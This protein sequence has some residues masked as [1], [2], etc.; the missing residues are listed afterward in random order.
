MSVGSDVLSGFLGAASFRAPERI[1]ESAWLQHAPFAYWLTEALA[2]RVV[3]ELGAHLGFSYFTFCEA[4]D[5]AGLDNKLYAVDT[6]AGDAQAGFYGE[7]V[8]A[9]VEAYN[10]KRFAG[11]STL[12]RMRFDDALGRFSDG[13]IDLLHI[14]GAHG[15]DDVRGDFEAWLPK[16]TPRGVVLLHDVAV[17]REGFGVARF[18]NEVRTR[19]P[20]FSFQHGFGL[21]VLGTGPDVPEAVG[22]L[23]ALDPGSPEAD[24]VRDAYARLGR[25]VQLEHDLRFGARVFQLRQTALETENARLRRAVPVEPGTDTKP[26]PGEAAVAALSQRLDSLSNQNGAALSAAVGFLDSLMRRLDQSDVLLTREHERCEALGATVA[27]LRSE[28]ADAARR[29]AEA[30]AA[31]AGLADK[32]REAE[33]TIARLTADLVDVEA[34]AAGL[35]RRG[36]WLTLIAPIRRRIDAVRLYRNPLFDSAWYV[37]NYMKRNASRLAAIEHFLSDGY[38]SGCMPNPLFDTRWYLTHYDDVRRSGENPLLHYFA[39]GW[40]EGRNPGPAFDTVFYLERNPDVAKSRMNPLVHYIRF[41][42]KEGRQPVPAAPP[43]SNGFGGI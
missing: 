21:G 8:F 33:W 29:Q 36:R 26:T 19:H 32:L 18:W 6:W 24:L 43:P 38:A 16:L 23:F 20:H 22:R 34:S 40:A 28:L 39:V 35:A 14:D 15:Y 17:E 42:Q 2:P 31:S 37:E 30:E 3:V 12:L 11:R 9:G 4:S 13:S 27:G 5:R 7:D 25:G 1:V 41:G 10:A